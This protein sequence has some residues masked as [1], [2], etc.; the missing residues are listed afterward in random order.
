VGLAP[1]LL[2]PAMGRTLL[3]LAAA[4]DRTAGLWRMAPPL[5]GGSL[6]GSLLGPAL[7]GQTLLG[8]TLGTLLGLAP[9]LVVIAVSRPAKPA[10]SP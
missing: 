2:G 3:G 7:L 6:W 10:R 9:P 8:Q 1:A 4:V 5:L